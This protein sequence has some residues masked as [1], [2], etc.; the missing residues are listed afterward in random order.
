MMDL[1]LELCCPRC[2]AEM[3]EIDAAA[4]QPAVQQLRLCPDCY[5][6]T[7]NDENGIQIRQ[8]VPVKNLHPNE[9]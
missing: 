2:G 6:V 3:E 5:I 8:G 1:T 9:T 7:W 4:E